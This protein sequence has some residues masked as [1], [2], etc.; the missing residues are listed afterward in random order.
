MLH[1][2]KGFTLL[3]V[4][5]ALFIFTI[6]AIIMTSALHNTLNIQTA[7]EK[8]AQRLS[9]LQIALLLVSQDLEQT[10]DRPITDAKGSLQGAFIGTPT[11]ITFTHGGFANPFGK[12]NRSTLQRANYHFE[13]NT[14]IRETWPVLDQVSRTLSKN[15]K[16]LE[17]VTD[18]RFE[19]LD[20]KGVFHNNWPAEQYPTSNLPRAVRITLTLKNWG[21]LS[22]L[23]LIQGQSFAAQA[24]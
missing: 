16:L 23:Y 13:K 8:H 24:I 11:S 22:Q 17:E 3:E 19:F 21:K 7:T 9:Q 20:G 10:I 14:F 4:L 6:V 15:R 12:L 1:N 5:I 18:L 2:K